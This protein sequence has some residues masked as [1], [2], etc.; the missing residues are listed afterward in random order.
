MRRQRPLRLEALETRLTPTYNVSIE[1]FA[2]TT[3]FDVQTTATQV[4]FSANATGA[5]LSI[6]DILTALADGK[7]VQIN[8]GSGGGE[9]GDLQWL[10][11]LDFDAIDGARSLSVHAA[12]TLSV[13]GSMTD[14]NPFLS[15]DVLSVQFEWAATWIFPA[16]SPI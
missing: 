3:G 7:D 11:N 2:T 9:N 14:G 5:T 1:S 13:F 12:G 15:P 4:T 16:S 10:D 6:D 8:T